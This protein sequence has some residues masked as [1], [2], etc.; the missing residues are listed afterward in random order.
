MMLEELGLV[1]D[2]SSPLLGGIVTLLAFCI[3]GVMPL[4]PYIVGTGVKKD[5]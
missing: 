2:D 4:I 3:C 1:V 5:D